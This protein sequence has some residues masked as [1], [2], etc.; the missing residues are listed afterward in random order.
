MKTEIRLLAVALWVGVL[1]LSP[2]SALAEGPLVAWKVGEKVPEGQMLSVE[3]I[4]VSLRPSEGKLLLIL[5]E[6]FKLEN[7]TERTKAAVTLF[8]RFHTKGLSVVCLSPGASEGALW[9]PA[10]R[11][12]IPWPI[13]APKAD[14]DKPA[15]QLSGLSA[16]A[17]YLVD[18]QGSVVAV[19]VDGEKAHE[20]VA[21]LLKVSLDE[22]PM[23]KEPEPR[24]EESSRQQIVYELDASSARLGTEDE[25]KDAEP[26]RKNLRK[27]S[28]AITD[29]R[30]DHKGEL[31][32][33]L[34]DLYPKY[35]QDE[36]VLLCPGNSQP[37][38]GM[39]DFADPKMK[40]SYLY[41]FSPKPREQKEE[42]LGDF[43]DRVA[44]VRCRNHGRWLSLSYGGE[45]YFTQVVWENE[46]ARGAGL[47]DDDAKVRERLRMLAAALAEY[48]R[49]NGDVP[50]ELEDLVPKYVA[51]K[52]LL[53]CPVTGEPFSYQFSAST[54]FQGSTYREAKL[55]QLKDPDIGEYVPIIRAKGVLKNGNV[56]NLSY[57]GE[58][59]ES[60]VGWEVLFK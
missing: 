59:Y 45:I 33:H 24:K 37:L 20:T 4:P 44:M 12:Q 49:D 19:G 53:K 1:G 16:P 35:L 7:A 27:I 34:S 26:C 39:D 42:Q 18:A 15:S 8:R 25:R 48:R 38:E 14:G 29:Y 11:W 36:S 17:S 47:K 54:E 51:D 6:D 41:E 52:D 43:G 23:P 9:R 21:K 2:G 13:V 22:L 31:P 58:I 32:E 60:G 3:G 56:I 5:V 50:K 30:A 40:C 46:M 10:F 55:K 28:L 57:G